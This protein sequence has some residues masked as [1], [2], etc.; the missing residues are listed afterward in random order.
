MHYA[1]RE[2][3]KDAESGLI[4]ANAGKRVQRALVRYAE[5]KHFRANEVWA[6]KI[7]DVRL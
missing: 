6:I 1:E 2:Q 5:R 3:L 7:I 4:E